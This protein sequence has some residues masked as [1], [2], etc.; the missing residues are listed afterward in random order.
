MND[1]AT[2][3]YPKVK[4]IKKR[5][6]LQALTGSLG[7]VSQAV[8]QSGNLISRETHYTWLREDPDY[9]EAVASVGEHVLDF[10]ESALHK[11]I[12]LGK[13]QSL[14]FYLKTRGKSRGYSVREE[15]DEVGRNMLPP[16]I[17]I[18]M[19]QQNS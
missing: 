6:F 10:A 15:S 14:I 11:N 5:A 8:K 3:P 12:A 4:D 13:E 19:P 18:I 7:I 9:A 16:T 2:R 1:I 17:N